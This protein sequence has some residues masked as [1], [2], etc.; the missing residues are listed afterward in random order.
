MN[1]KENPFAPG[2][3]TQPPQLAGRTAIV[4][5]AE[6]AIARARRGLGKSLLLLGLRGVGKTVLLNRLAEV[7]RSE[8]CLA[9]TLEATEAQRLPEMLVPPLRAALFQLSRTE[10]AADRANRALAVL[11][12]FAAAF[13]VKL[14]DVE[15][16]LKPEPGTADSGN[17]EFDLTALLETIA[18]AARAE[19]RALVLLID[20]LQFLGSGDLAA[21]IVATHRLGQKNLPFL[22]IGAGLPQLAALAG[23]AK[24]YA[25]RLFDYPDVGPLT[26]DAAREAIRAPLTRATLEIRDEA[27][28]HIVGQTAGYPYFLQEW[29]YQTWN[30]AAGSPITL[31]DAKLATMAALQRLDSSFFKVRGDRLTPRERDYVNA[32]ASLGPGPHRS[33]EIA[34][35]MA[36]KVSTVAPLRDALIKKGMLYSPRHGETAF[37]VPMFDEYLKRSTPAQ[38]P[39][40]KG[41]R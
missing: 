39:K 35:A 17:L 21:L 5:D 11:R 32:M 28:A 36:Q 7:A 25:E 23:E 19:Q 34:A 27:L 4:T 3:G 22:F 8:G 38:A 29:G 31:G 12:S 18:E 30:A 2:A 20:E 26:A 14:G 16:G 24:S 15:V 1:P 40:R 41:K 9:L 6:V 37:T 13:K 33:G 10:R